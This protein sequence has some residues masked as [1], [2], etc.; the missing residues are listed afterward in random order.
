MAEVTCSLL[1]T[2]MR[3]LQAEWASSG[4]IAS[5]DFGG[6]EVTAAYTSDVALSGT[7]ITA[8]PD[9]LSLDYQTALAFGPVETGS[10]AS[11]SVAKAWM[12]QNSYNDST[13]TGSVIL[14]REN[15]TGDDWRTG[16]VLFEYSGSTIDEIDL[17]FDQSAR[18]TVSAERQDI[19]NELSQSQVWFYR[20]STPLSAFTFSGI[21]TGSSPR[22]MLD[23]PEDVADSDVVLFYVKSI[24]S[25]MN[26]GGWGIGGYIEA[27]GSGISGD[28]SS[29]YQDGLTTLSLAPYHV[30]DPAIREEGKFTSQP[31]TGPSIGITGSFNPPGVAS[32]G[33]TI[34]DPD[35]AGNTVSAYN[36][37]GILIDQKSFIYDGTPGV[38]TKDTQFIN[39]P[40]GTYIRTFRL[41]P[42][43]SDYVG[44]DAVYFEPTTGSLPGTFSSQ[45]VYYRQQRDNYAIEYPVPLTEV[46]FLEYV[47]WLYGEYT[48][49][50]GEIET[51]SFQGDLVWRGWATGSL[52]GA[53]TGTFTASSGFM[54]ESMDTG[55]FT[56]SFTGSL[57]GTFQGYA[58][59]A[60]T[61]TLWGK[62]GFQGSDAVFVGTT[63]SSLVAGEDFLYELFL[64]DVVKLRDN[65]LALYVTRRNIDSGSSDMG[66]Y[67]AQKLETILYPQQ[68]SEDEYTA[69]VSY[70]T[71]SLYPLID[72]FVYD[73]DS[74]VSGSSL[75]YS[76]SMREIVVTQSV[77]DV[78]SFVSGSA[79]IDSASMRSIVITHTVYDVDSFVTGSA[80][81]T[82]GSVSEIIVAHPVYDKDSFVS[83]SAIIWSA[84]L[85]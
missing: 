82:S 11:G 57:S 51:G 78:D 12:V 53:W 5:Y 77:Y 7:S 4:T 32:L 50:I 24:T 33:V 56:G 27:T 68:I 26:S 8:R 20:Y 37:G 76:S 29:S 9:S 1:P 69:S 47:D 54:T 67:R 40:S 3:E 83:G 42:A 84:S 81:I 49:T 75:I 62:R 17:S 30:S 60:I 80:L 70:L 61:G 41:H 66:E 79:L 52:S 46:S 58:S 21:A 35:Y 38:V 2:A 36:S 16:L 6:G 44:Y 31:D 48:G 14:S 59:G 72:H 34:V 64:E 19:V 85:E 23:A 55:S 45:Q 10:T 74:F 39:P 65:R 15:D 18:P 73:V 71:S 13:L 28:F 63:S 43:T 22:V 25:E